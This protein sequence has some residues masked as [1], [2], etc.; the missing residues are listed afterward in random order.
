MDRVPAPARI[1]GWPLSVN[2]VFFKLSRAA[3]NSSASTGLV[4]EMVGWARLWIMR[5][6]TGLGPGIRSNFSPDILILK[7]L[8]FTQFFPQNTR[9]DQAEGLK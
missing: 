9:R 8:Y 7:E 3:L 1:K 5:G 6:C 2:T 4:W